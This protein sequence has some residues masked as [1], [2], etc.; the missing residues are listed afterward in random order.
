MG[1]VEEEWGLCGVVELEPSVETAVGVVDLAV[2]GEDLNRWQGRLA[3]KR[4]HP[5]HPHHP[6][7][8][9]K[10]RDIKGL[11]LLKET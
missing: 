5:H 3:P 8:G 10:S 6:L 2:G 7:W 1:V 9:I 11:I 4:H